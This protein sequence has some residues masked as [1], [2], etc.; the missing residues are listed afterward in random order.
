MN[1]RD[2]MCEDGFVHHCLISP[3]TFSNAFYLS[4][5]DFDDDVDDDDYKHFI[6]FHFIKDKSA[7]EFLN[8]VHDFN[9]R[10]ELKSV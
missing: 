2:V 10:F 7:V 3:E 6:S 1:E 4:I 8:T 9:K 5:I